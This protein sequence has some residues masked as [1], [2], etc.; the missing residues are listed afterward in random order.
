MKHSNYTNYKV[1]VPRSYPGLCCA[2]VADSSDCGPHLRNSGE[3]PLHWA[4][5]E[6]KT[7]YISSYKTTQNVILMDSKLMFFSC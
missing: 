3:K 6:E 4:S 5:A 7:I 1:C 2:V